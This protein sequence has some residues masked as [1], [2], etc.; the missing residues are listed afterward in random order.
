MKKSK[1]LRFSES[2]LQ[3]ILNNNK[4]V[5][6]SGVTPSKENETFQKLTIERE[7]PKKQEKLNILPENTSEVVEKVKDKTD[8]KKIITANVEATPQVIFSEKEVIFFFDGARLLSM[9]QIFNILQYRNYEMFNYKKTWHLII[10]K[11]INQNKDLPFF[12]KGIEIT[13]LRIAPRLVD[14]DALGTMFKFIIDA[15]KEKNK[16]KIDYFKGII[17]EDNPNILKNIKLKQF[18]GRYGVGI[19]I[20]AVEDSLLDEDLSNFLKLE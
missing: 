5:K 17:P 9:N 11:L 2:S 10:E 12:D 16:G 20:K 8:V 18:K 13:I 19:K 7:K 4:N 14:M 1:G 3:E 15:L 6:V